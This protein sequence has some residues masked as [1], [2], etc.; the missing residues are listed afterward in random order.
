ME[1]RGTPTALICTDSFLPEA[2]RVAEI[3]GLPHLPIVQIPHPL[4][5]LREEEILQRAQHA[6]PAIENILTQAL[7]TQHPTP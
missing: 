7:K 3:L 6:L 1:I 5:T 2:Q 4:S